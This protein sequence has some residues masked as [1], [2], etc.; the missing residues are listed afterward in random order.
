MGEWFMVNFSTRS[1]AAFEHPERR[2]AERFDAAIGAIR[3]QRRIGGLRDKKVVLVTAGHW[4]G[5]HQSA[6]RRFGHHVGGGDHFALGW[7]LGFSSDGNALDGMQS[8]YDP[9]ARRRGA[10]GP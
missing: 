1:L 9:G 3:R 4:A 2:I 10:M 6:L 5:V 8:P 7:H